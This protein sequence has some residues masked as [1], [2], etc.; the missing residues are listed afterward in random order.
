MGCHHS[1]TTRNEEGYLIPIEEGAWLLPDGTFAEGIETE[2]PDV[3]A[4]WRSYFECAKYILT[5]FAEGDTGLA[6]IAY[7]LNS[8]GWAFRDRWGQ[9]RA[10]NRDDIRR[11]VGN[12]AEYGGIIVDGRGKDRPS[13]ESFDPD[14][15][16]FVEDR[17][18][19]PIELLQKVARIKQK[20]TVRPKDKGKVRKARSYPLSVITL[21]AHCFNQAEKQDN[22]KL[23]TTLRGKLDAR[24]VRR[25]IHRSGV[26]CG[27]KNRSVPCEVIEAD[28]IRIV[29]LMTIDPEMVDVMVEFAIQADKARGVFTEEDL[30]DKKREAIALCQRRLNA[31]VV[32]FDEGRIDYEAYRARIEKNERKIA[33]WNTRTTQAEKVAFELAR[34]IE[35]VNDL[36]QLWENAEPEEK[37]N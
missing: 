17:A 33:Y 32:L 31:A 13:Y 4:L 34:C 14:T 22:P 7:R 21:C 19:M 23:R 6:R 10:M 27:C 11:V 25:Y 5:I 30:E 1:A 8:E 35:A 29:K 24:E 20:R 37:Q 12:W 16:L 28:F 26:N 15:I 3:N 36:V 2:K 18:V 9:P